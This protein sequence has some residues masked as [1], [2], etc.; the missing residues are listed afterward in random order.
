[1][2]FA[3]VPETITMLY[4]SKMLGQE[5]SRFI[6]IA[7]LISLIIIVIGFILVGPIYGIIGLATI[8]VI[9]SVSQTGFL[10]ISDKISKGG[11]NVR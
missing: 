1:M 10:V 11:K 7:K 4:M 2:S 8:L 3:V 9:A 5:K 6:L